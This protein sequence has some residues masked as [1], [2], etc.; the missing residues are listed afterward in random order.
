M[1]SIF[2]RKHFFLIEFFFIIFV[3]SIN[4]SLLNN[5]IKNIEEQ[6]PIIKEPSNIQETYNFFRQLAYSCATTSYDK[7][8]IQ[9][10]CSDG[11]SSY[12][13]VLKYNTV[14]LK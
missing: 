7:V 10:E 11:P 6:T 1:F 5:Q 14:I 4:S 2:K 12:D 13:R 3:A 8:E 9:D